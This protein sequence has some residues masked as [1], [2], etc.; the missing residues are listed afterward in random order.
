TLM[1]YLL[2]DFT[3]NMRTRMLEEEKY[4]IG[5]L[6]KDR[7]LLCHSMSG[8]ETITQTWSVIPRMLDSDNVIR[9]IS[10]NRDDKNNEIYA[11]FWEKYPSKSFV[12]WL[13]ISQKDAIH[14]FGG[15]YRIYT[16]V[17]GVTTVLEIKDEEIEDWIQQHPEIEHSKIRLNQP[18]EDLII[19]QII[20]GTKKFTSSKGFL[21]YFYTTKYTVEHFREEFQKIVQELEYYSPSPQ[22]FED[23][24]GVWQVEGNRESLRITKKINDLDVIFSTN[25]IKCKEEY[26]DYLYS[27]FANGDKINIYHVGVPFS[28]K[29]VEIKHMKIWNSLKICET[30]NKIIEYFHS[31]N[32]QDK[33]LLTILEY[34]IFYLLAENNKDAY[35]YFFL[36]K[37]AQRFLHG[38]AESHVIS[39]SEDY[40]LEYKASEFF[41][42]SDEEIINKAVIDIKNKS[43]NSIIKIYI[44]GVGDQG[45]VELIPKS[46]VK[47]DR[48]NNIKDEIKMKTSAKDVYLF[49]IP[50]EKGCLLILV[51]LGCKENG[52]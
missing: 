51:W 44:I 7:I 23:R 25:K 38:I 29:P 28:D 13:G 20:V 49:P 43:Q 4:I 48:L 5:I 14:Y 45:E 34:I 42:G 15:R 6:L 52:K 21:Q 33:I 8:E 11:N 24:E 27:K 36:V 19:T 47:S 17:G 40:I 22:F 46:R 9:Y 2:N 3:D 10:F 35:I 18:V 39:K 32:L 1:N 12:E 30:T 16:E 50:L 26:L 37:F 31:T 41:S